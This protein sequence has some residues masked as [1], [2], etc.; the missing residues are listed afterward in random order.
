MLIESY[1]KKVRKR[2][3]NWKKKVVKKIRRKSEGKKTCEKD[4]KIKNAKNAK[5]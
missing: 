1:G 3:E 4:E 5:I 2:D